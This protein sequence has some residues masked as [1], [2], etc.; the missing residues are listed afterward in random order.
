MKMNY[1][2]TRS[3]TRS[4]LLTMALAAGIAFIGSANAQYKVTGE[5][6]VTASPRARAQ[7]D[8]RKATV[9]TPAVVSPAMACPTC[10]ASATRKVDKTVRGA[11][12]PSVLVTKHL[13]ASCDTA[14]ITTGVGKAKT[15][16][17]RHSCTAS[18]VKTAPC[19]TSGNG[20]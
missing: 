5:D 17:A 18:G 4:L 14:I 12:K 8:E 6:G 1:R 19:C 15:D 16:V 3:V 20:S 2:N 11:N 10:K 7:I 13:C 9:P